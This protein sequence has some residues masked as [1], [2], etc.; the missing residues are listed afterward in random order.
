MAVFSESFKD[1]VRA[2]APVTPTIFSIF[3]GFGI[4]ASLA[5]VPASAT[6]LMSALIYAVPAQYA[7]LDVATGGAAGI[8]QLALVGAMAN[9]RFFV[10]GMW[11][12]QA[13]RG[14][15]LKRAL[16]LCHFVAATPFLLL[17]LKSKKRDGT[18]LFEFY[19]GISA[20]LPV[21]SML[22]TATGIA[23]GAALPGP[24]KFGAALFMPIYFGILLASEL[25][26]KPEMAAVGLGAALTPVAEALAPGWGLLLGP[27][28]TGALVTAVWR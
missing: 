3:M 14:T 15:P 1:G 17:F 18:D 27:A 25:K 28:A 10:M 8:I 7:I 21:P 5:G 11:M 13:F 23:I 22:G 26:G 9:L 2:V 12:A 20:V 19:K 24:L 4:S 16:S 6:M